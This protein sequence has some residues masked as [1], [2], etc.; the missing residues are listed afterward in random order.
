VSIV[1]RPSSPIRS[2]E[3]PHEVSTTAIAEQLLAHIAVI[4]RRSRYIARDSSTDPH[5]TTAQIELLR[6]IDLNPGFT[7]T[8]AATEL[9]L[10]ANTVSTL[11]GQ[12]SRLGLLDRRY[13]TDDR[14]VIHL[15]VTEASKRRLTGWRRR[16]LN[17]VTKALSALDEEE[18]QR[19]A[20][21]L[22]ALGQLGEELQP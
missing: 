12:L 14:R 2:E 21:A 6:L 15:E 1:P 5:L 20:S 22:G 11:V 8:E 13:D 4:R 9:H 18:R 3:R 17:A 10:A 7:V 16:R 19:I